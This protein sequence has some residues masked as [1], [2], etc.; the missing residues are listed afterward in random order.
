MREYGEPWDQ[1]RVITL[2]TN[3]LISLDELD[4]MPGLVA[5]ARTIA[6]GMDDPRW[7]LAAQKMELALRIATN[8]LD[9]AEAELDAMDAVPGLPEHAAIDN[10]TMRGD[11]AFLRGSYELAAHHYAETA[12]R[13]GSQ[14]MENVLYQVQGIAASLAALGRDAEGT[15]L[16]SILV[17]NNIIGE[18]S[19]IGYGSAIAVVLLLISL[20][21]II[22]YLIATFRKER[23]A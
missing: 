15:E 5:E 20:A 14:D 2:I 19:R 16:L 12:R 7:M 21:V 22:P 9:R 18:S 23:R 10:E 4:E 8:D 3:H 6:A 1:L 17:T 11:I 13:M